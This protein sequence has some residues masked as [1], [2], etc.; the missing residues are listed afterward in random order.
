MSGKR[1]GGLDLKV[2]RIRTRLP[3]WRVAAKVGIHAPE[4]SL[5]ENERVEPSPGLVKRI[6]AAIEELAGERADGA[7]N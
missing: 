7:E 5:I 1:I 2:K 6:I 4:L 3:Q